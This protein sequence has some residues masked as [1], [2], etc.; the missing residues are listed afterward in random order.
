MTEDRALSGQWMEDVDFS[1]PHLVV[2]P[3][4]WEWQEVEG[5]ILSFTTPQLSK[6]EDLGT[7]AV[8]ILCVKVRHLQSLQAKVASRWIEFFGPG[9]SP[10]GCW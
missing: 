7:K 2:S 5:R 10:K 8:Y 6:F 4:V 9:S 1:F 3:S